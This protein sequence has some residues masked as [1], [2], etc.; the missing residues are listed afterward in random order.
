MTSSYI[1][2]MISKTQLS[3]KIIKKRNPVLV[4]TIDKLMKSNKDVAQVLARPISKQVKLNVSEIENKAEGNVLIPGKVLGDGEINKKMKIVA[5]SA[6]KG[7]VEKIKKAN[8]EFVLLSEEIKKNPE[9][10]DLKVIK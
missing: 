5:F 3:K 6:T 4:E 10:K 7:A 1:N 9:L 8:G 2:K